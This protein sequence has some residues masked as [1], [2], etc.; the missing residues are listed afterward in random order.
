MNLSLFAESRR[1]LSQLQEQKMNPDQAREA[2]S[3]EGLVIDIESLLDGDLSDEPEP[4]IDWDSFFEQ[5]ATPYSDYS[6]MIFVM[7]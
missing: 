3:I 4:E 5:V 1:V 7:A 2:F 6:G